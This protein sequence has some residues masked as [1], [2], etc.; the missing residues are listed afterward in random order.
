[1]PGT[2]SSSRRTSVVLPEPG[3]PMTRIRGGTVSWRRRQESGAAEQ[4]EDGRGIPRDH[5]LTERVPRF[6][7]PD[8]F[9][10]REGV[11]LDSE[12]PF[13]LSDRTSPG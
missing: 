5:S 9:E 11:V 4:S 1:M 13:T 3:A 10:G 12:I 2:S 7:E 6:V 8:S